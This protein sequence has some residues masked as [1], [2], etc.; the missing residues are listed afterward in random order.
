MG[1]L[2]NSEGTG[3][4]RGGLPGGTFNER[5]LALDPYRNHHGGDLRSVPGAA[6]LAERSAA[7]PRSFVLLGPT[8]FV[9]NIKACSDGG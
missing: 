9:N 2:K 7:G 8:A 5:S 6:R 1:P 3:E 4:G